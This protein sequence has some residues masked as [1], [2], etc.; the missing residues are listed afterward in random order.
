MNNDIKKNIR[1]IFWLLIAMFA[2]AVIYLGRFILIDS[3]EIVNNPFNPRLR[4]MTENVARGQITDSAGVILAETAAD[5]SRLYPFG[6]TLAH[7]VG[8]DQMGRS[9][10]EARYNVILRQPSMEIIQRVMSLPDPESGRVAGDTAALTVDIDIQQTLYQAFGDNRG[11]AVVMEPS[12][13]RILAMVSKPDFDPARIAADWERLIEDVEGSPLLNRATQGLYPPG[14]VFKSMTAAAALDSGLAE[15]IFECVGVAEFD[16]ESLRCF[17]SVAHG[18]I[19]MPEAFAV[20][21][22]GYF[23]AV[24]LEM[25]AGALY[26]ACERAFFNNDLSYSIERGRSSFVLTSGASVVDI[27]HTAIGQGQTLVTPLHMCMVTSAI[28]NGGRMMT[29]YILGKRVSA[30]GTVLSRNLPEKLTQVFDGDAAAAITGMMIEAVESGTAAPAAVAGIAIAA[31]TGTAQNASGDD[32]GWVIAFAPADD[33]Q[34]AI[35]V[36]TENSGGPRLGLEL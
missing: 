16:G 6:R 22:N 8:T 28:A 27:M 14:S 10:V 7:L 19:G 34:I 21:C 30:T 12:T 33:P 17:N 11:A 20:S 15:F 3:P 32:H 9:G 36:V 31:K 24:A 18:T 35:A 23:A 1:R 4:L 5:G 25:G 26:K 2:L 29:P 13:G